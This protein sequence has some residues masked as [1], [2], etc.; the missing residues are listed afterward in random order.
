MRTAVGVIQYLLH[1]MLKIEVVFF[2]HV[3]NG[4]K[5]LCITSYPSLYAKFL[6][7]F[8]RINDM[9]QRKYI[10]K[11]KISL[12]IKNKGNRLNFAMAAISA[13]P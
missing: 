3:K 12:E 8:S 13:F 11:S 10:G 7:I 5:L 2:F 9:G 6:R 1:P 4:L